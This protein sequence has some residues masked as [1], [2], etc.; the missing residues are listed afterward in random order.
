MTELVRPLHDLAAADEPRFGGKSAS[1]GELIRAGVN[2]PAGFAVSTDAFDTFMQ[3]D[4]LGA[5]IAALLDGLDPSDYE[6][7]GRAA[8][9]VATEMAATPVP[10]DVRAAIETSYDALAASA[11]ETDVAVAVR[12]SARGE[13]SADATF[14]GQQETVLWVRGGDAVCDA[15]RTCWTSLYSPPAIAYRRRLADRGAAAMGVTVQ[16]MVDASVSGVMF[17]C[18]P[19]TGDPSIIAINASW[20]LG[21][22]VVGG[23]VTPDDVVVSKVTGEVLR[24]TTSDKLVEYVPDPSGRGAVRQAVPVERRQA[25]CLGDDELPALVELARSIDRYF[26]SRQDIEF[27]IART[28]TYPSNLFALQARPVTTG[29]RPQAVDAASAMSRV[30]GT[31]GV[32]RPEV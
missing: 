6:S 4:A 23:E 7:L 12:S 2:V 16:C 20:G 26:G 5:R 15:L 8:H 14:A 30:L 3:V 31:F 18:S 17:T 10:D 1:L 29:A 19:L 11:G 22:A 32:G 25:P 13:D 21:L 27:A 24:A 9:R 28:G